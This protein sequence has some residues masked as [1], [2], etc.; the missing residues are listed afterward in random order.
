MATSF[1]KIVNNALPFS[2]FS[3]SQISILYQSKKEKLFE[4]LENNNFSRDMLKHVN[5]FSKDNYTC[6]YYDEDSIRNVKHKHLPDCLKC[7]HLNIVS[8]NK[9][10]V[11]LAFYLSCLSIIFDI[12]CLTEISRSTEELIEKEFPDHLCYIDETKTS[13]GGVA[14]LIRM[15][16]FD[17]VTELEPIKPTCNCSKCQTENKWLSFKINNQDCIV[18]GI[19]RHPSGDPEHF[20]TALNDTISKIKDNTLAITLG[21]IKIDLLDDSKSN[22]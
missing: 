1:Y 11:D 14:L 19:Y 16:K 2:S 6:N 22:T 17:N 13:K 20:S 12:I 8:F 15:N 21:D 18:G 4:T 10:G 5:G 9:N 7:F 3:S